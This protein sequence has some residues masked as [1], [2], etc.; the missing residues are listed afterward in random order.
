M[1]VR[2]R[3]IATVEGTTGSPVQAS[4]TVELDEELE[5]IVD[6]AILARHQEGRRASILEVQ[7][8]VAGLVGGVLR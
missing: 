3:R 4:E 8:D 6:G 7:L 1:S 5:R 2:S